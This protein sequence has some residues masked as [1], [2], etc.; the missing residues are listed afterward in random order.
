MKISSKQKRALEKVTGKPWDT[1]DTE[2]QCAYFAF[3]D[4]GEEQNCTNK[5][6]E[7]LMEYHRQHPIIV[8]MW[9]QDFKVGL[10]YLWDFLQEDYPLAFIEHSFEIYEGV[11]GF[12]P[13]CYRNHPR[14]PIKYRN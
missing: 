3:T 5:D 14:T 7:I 10:L 13:T 6:F 9:K 8:E 12:I 2:V 11:M 1:F 4:R